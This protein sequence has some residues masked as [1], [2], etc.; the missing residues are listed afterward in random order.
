MAITAEPM[1]WMGSKLSIKQANA[2]TPTDKATPGTD[3]NTFIFCLL[4]IRFCMLI[5]YNT[6]FSELQPNLSNLHI[7]LW[8]EFISP[9]QKKNV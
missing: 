8:D 6:F 5:Q 3:F 9:E 2:A 1:T 4:S 7:L